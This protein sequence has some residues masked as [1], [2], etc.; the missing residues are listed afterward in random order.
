[1]AERG[2]EVLDGYH[3]AA[4]NDIGAGE[5]AFA[6]AMGLPEPPTA[7]LCATDQVALGALAGAL[8]AGV[9]IPDDLSVIG[10]DDIPVAR[11]SVP[12]LTTVR[13]PLDELA[14]RAVDEVIAIIRGEREAVSKIHYLRP[15][16]VVRGSA[17][18]PRRPR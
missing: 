9:R 2:L 15:E 17:A 14:A 4:E 12:P 16:L 18:P 7:I 11:F 1:V 5:E 8:R 13:Q 6:R 10:F 3:Q